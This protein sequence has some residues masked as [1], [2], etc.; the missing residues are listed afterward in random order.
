VSWPGGCDL[1]R[2]DGPYHTKS[3]FHFPKNRPI[4]SANLPVVYCPIPG[5]VREAEGDFFQLR[6]GVGSNPSCGGGGGIM[7]GQFRRFSRSQNNMLSMWRL[8]SVNILRRPSNGFMAVSALPPGTSV[9]FYCRIV[10]N[11]EVWTGFRGAKN[12]LQDQAVVDPFPVGRKPDREFADKLLVGGMEVELDRL[13]SHGRRNDR[14]E[15]ARVRP[16]VRYGSNLLS[17][18]RC[19]ARRTFRFGRRGDRV[20]CF[21]R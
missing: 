8:C 9:D 18:W 4:R 7:R 1:V 11:E 5:T 17:S 3:D 15:M 16:G 21:L 6:R 2:P 13:A 20:G 14:A 10:G 19:F 12:G